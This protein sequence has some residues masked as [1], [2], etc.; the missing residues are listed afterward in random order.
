M[1]PWS[2]MRVLAGVITTG[3]GACTPETQP[4]GA[5]LYRQNCGACHGKTGAGDGPLAADLPV[6]PANLR[7]LA[8]GN[9]G[10][11]PTERVMKSIHGYRGKDYVGL[12]PEFGP[13]LDSPTVIWVAPDGREIPTPSALVA[14]VAYLETLQD[15]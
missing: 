13:V 11:F 12:M 3:L 14:L 15:L 4:S 10:V 8:S 1:K 2:E 5:A 6:R 9:D 7:L